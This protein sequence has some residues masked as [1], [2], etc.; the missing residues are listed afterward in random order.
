MLIASFT[1][2]QLPRAAEYPEFR[3]ATREV[4]T[5]LNPPGAK[6]VGEAGTV[7]ELGA[8]MNAINDALAPLEA[9]RA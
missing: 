1:D 4:P 5:A 9:N 6:I 3:P 2:Y 8:A 7:G